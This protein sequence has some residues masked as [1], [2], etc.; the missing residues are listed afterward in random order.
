MIL[1]DLCVLPVLSDEVAW[2]ESE[3]AAPERAATSMR[4]AF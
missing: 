3:A 2:V 4:E 1:D